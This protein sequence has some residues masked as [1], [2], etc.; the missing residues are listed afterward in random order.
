MCSLVASYAYAR[1]TYRLWFVAEEWE[2]VE[3]GEEEMVSDVMT[4]V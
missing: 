2:I 3:N 1:H 4:L